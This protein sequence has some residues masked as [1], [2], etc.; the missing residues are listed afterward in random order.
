MRNTCQG[1]RGFDLDLICEHHTGPRHE[2]AASKAG[3]MSAPDN[4][5]KRS[6]IPSCARGGY[7]C[8]VNRLLGKQPLSPVKSCDGSGNRR[9]EGCEAVKDSDANL[10]LS[11][12]PVEGFRHEALPELLDT[13]HVSFHTATAMIAAPVSPNGSTQPFACSQGFITR[14]CAITGWFPEASIPARRNNCRGPSGGDG[15]VTGARIE[16]SIRGHAGDAV[17]GIN[18]I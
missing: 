15:I 7:T 9:S 5:P 14:F 1:A 12:L 4:A 6:K 10:N 17:T 18:L 11:D 8:C 13:V 16:C 2:M 3:Y